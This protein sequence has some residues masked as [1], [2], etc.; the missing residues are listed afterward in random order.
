MRGE[1]S[2][3]RDA[4]DV[5]AARKSRLQLKRPLLA[6]NRRPCCQVGTVIG[7]LGMGIPLVKLLVTLHLPS[8]YRSNPSLCTSVQLDAQ[9]ALGMRAV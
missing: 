5:L 1:T 9:L 6:P 2:S 7:S 4:A 3:H 8:A